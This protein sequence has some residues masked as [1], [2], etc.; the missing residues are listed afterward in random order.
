MQLDFSGYDAV[1]FDL[2]GTLVLTEHVWQAAKRSVAAR[3][4]VTVPDATLHAHTGR[5]LT[6]FVSEQL[7]TANDQPMAF[8]VAVAAIEAEAL[9]RLG[10]ELSAVPGA[11][12]LIRQLHESGHRLAICSSSSLKAIHIA[13][14]VLAIRDCFQEIFSAAD[15]P[16]GKPDP[17]PFLATAQL[18]GVAPGHCVAIEDSLAGVTSATSAGMFTIAVGNEPG[19]AE[20]GLADL[21]CPHLADLIPA[22][23]AV[24]PG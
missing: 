13:L 8:G 19:V 4:D 17:A 1:I 6:D 9:Q 14:D 20:S 7:F 3:F 22:G 16:L 10:A 21:I 24:S 12:L 15:L 11:Q 18:M 5:R 2:D 23:A